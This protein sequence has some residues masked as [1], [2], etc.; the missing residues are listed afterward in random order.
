MSLPVTI[1][2]RI[3]PEIDLLILSF[4]RHRALPKGDIW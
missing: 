1:G 4:H 2:R 3:P